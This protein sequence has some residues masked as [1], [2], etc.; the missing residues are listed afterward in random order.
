MK[1]CRKIG[2]TYGTKVDHRLCLFPRNKFRGYN[3]GL[4]YG[5]FN[6]LLIA[7]KKTIERRTFGP[8]ISIHGNLNYERFEKNTVGMADMVAMDFNHG[9]IN[10]E[11]FEKIP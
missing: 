10:Y 6:W 11:R 1:K 4:A 9:N 5:N 7:F 3:V 2:R 8:W